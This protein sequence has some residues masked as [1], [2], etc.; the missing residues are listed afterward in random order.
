MS[1]IKLVVLLFLIPAIAFAQTTTEEAFSP[2]QGATALIVRTIGEAQKSVHV[3]AYSFTS[4][5]IADALVQIH[6][7]GIDVEVVLDKSQSKGRH[8]LVDF[9]EANNIPTRINA[10]YAIMHNKFMI[11]DDKVLELGS[12]NYTKAAENKNAENVLVLRDDPQAVAGYSQQWQKLWDEGK[13]Q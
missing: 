8:K 5:P 6:Q 9:L 7:R 4:Q 11:I 10:H 3:A 13:E 2:H 1:K 12:F